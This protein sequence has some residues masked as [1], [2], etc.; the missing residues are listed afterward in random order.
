M[1]AVRKT[2]RIEHSTPKRARFRAL[3]ESAGWST[4][5]AAA[6]VEVVQGTAKHWLHK[7]TDSRTGK[8]RPGRP[9]II[10]KEQVEAIDKWFTGHYEHCICSLTDIIKSSN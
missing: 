10:T 5:Q 4:R 9:P 8:L 6:E 7:D 3:V 1:G 2:S